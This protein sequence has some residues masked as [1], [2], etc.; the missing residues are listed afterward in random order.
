MGYK[1]FNISELENFDF[2]LC[3]GLSTME[4]VRKSLD[5]MFFV[6]EGESFNDFTIEEILIKMNE[7]NWTKKINEI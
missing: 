6:G 5:G 1:I 3:T 7:S 2:S 4:S